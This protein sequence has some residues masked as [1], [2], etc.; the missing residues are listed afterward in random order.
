MMVKVTVNWAWWPLPVAP[1]LVAVGELLPVSD[2][3]TYCVPGQSGLA[4]ETLAQNKQAETIINQSEN[5]QKQQQTKQTKPQPKQ[6]Q[7]KF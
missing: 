5:E 6:K 4:S 3:S 1:A 2:C 7:K